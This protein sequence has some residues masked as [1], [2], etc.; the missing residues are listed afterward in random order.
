MAIPK[1]IYCAVLLALTLSVTACS[2][3]TSPSASPTVTSA[4]SASATATPTP[5]VTTP[6][7]TPQQQ[8]LVNAQNAVV[9]LWAVVDRLT[10]DKKS[11]IQDLD[12]VASG[13]V[14]TFFQK[15]VSGYRAEGLVGTGKTVVEPQSAKLA[16]T[17]NEGLTTWTVV[18]CI[19]MSHAKLVDSSGKS[20]VGPPYRIQRRSTVIER[21]GSLFVAQDEVLGTC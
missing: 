3:T 20:V 15:N 13:E 10:N 11:S 19:D 1:R 7:L 4:S 12:N 14:R 2:P 21:D 6:S 5:T 16:G 8:D 17:N 9:K 18:A